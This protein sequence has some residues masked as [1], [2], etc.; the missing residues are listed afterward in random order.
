MN[1]LE[2]F[3]LKAITYGVFSPP[4]FFSMIGKDKTLYCCDANKD[5]LYGIKQDGTIMF[6]FSSGDFRR[7]IGVADQLRQDVM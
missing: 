7:P 3:L 4:F 1:N 5:T 6:S 2:D